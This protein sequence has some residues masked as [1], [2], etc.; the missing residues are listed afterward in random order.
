VGVL[1]GGRASARQWEPTRFALIVERL[2][3]AGHRVVVFG[4]A[5]ERPL[6]ALVAGRYAVD[7]GGRCS[8]PALAAGLGEC[9][10]LFTNDSGPMHLAASVGTRTISLWGAGDPRRT[11]P[12]GEGHHLLR[13]PELSCV[14]CVRNRCPRNG[15]GTYLPHAERE[16]LALITVEQA[17]SAVVA[18]LKT[19]GAGGR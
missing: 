2:S 7:L 17:W 15:A 9:D 5:D 1:P 3:A 16:C 11:G 19:C 18:M 13:H 4:G 6:T 10:L 12:L 8:L 14:P